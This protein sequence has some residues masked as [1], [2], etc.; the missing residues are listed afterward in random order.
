MSDVKESMGDESFFT[1]TTVD[2]TLNSTISD[3][4]IS[5]N[6]GMPLDYSVFP[7]TPESINITLI[8]PDLSNTS[9]KSKLSVKSNV[10][11]ASKTNTNCSDVCGKCV[12]NQLHRKHVSTQCNIPPSGN[13]CY[14]CALHEACNNDN[15]IVQQV[16]Q[17]PYFGR[18]LSTL[19]NSDQIRDF[20]Y[21]MQ[22]IG[23]GDMSTHN[24]AWKSALY[25]GIWA[26]C[27]STVGMWYDKEFVEFWSIINLLF[28]GSATN[29]LQGP[30][31]FGHVVSEK[32]TK[33]LYKP[34]N[35]EC[36]FALPSNHTLKRM[37]TGYDRII[38]PGFVDHTLDVA[39]EEASQGVQF[40]VTLDGKTV[41]E[42]SKGEIDGDIDLWG[43]DKQ[44]SNVTE[45][46]HK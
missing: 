22:A 30:V 11:Q 9:S 45:A 37:D 2:T 39:Q 26:T 14:Y 16:V 25:R 18:F 31:H 8:S 33:N 10:N 42:G 4:E 15:G 29:V 36:N 17:H 24:I 46:L 27:K 21:L 43:V 13:S 3:L 6:D 7:T 23:S 1:N 12:C 28:G 41:A 44:H 38:L 5:N 34:K 35:S 20:T 32:S 40:C 19:H